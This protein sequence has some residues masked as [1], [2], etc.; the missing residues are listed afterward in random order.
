MTAP[1]SPP[2]E[3][4]AELLRLASRL[5]DEAELDGRMNR[6]TGR[7]AGVSAWRDFKK[8]IES[9][10]G[11]DDAIPPALREV[12]GVCS[13]GDWPGD[14]VFANGHTKG[15]CAQC[16]NEFYGHGL[17]RMCRVCATLII[18]QGAFTPPRVP[19]PRLERAAGGLDDPDDMTGPEEIK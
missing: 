16:G 5:K 14:S 3:W 10:H 13:S 2:P 12:L 19:R 15:T 4:W 6:G 7:P 8:H 9:R 1:V 17:R 18:D 11:L